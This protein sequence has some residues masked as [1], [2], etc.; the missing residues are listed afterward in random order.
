MT[1]TMATATTE[2]ATRLH[3]IPPVFGLPFCLRREPSH[4]GASNGARVF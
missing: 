2:R 1:A 3:E 4:H